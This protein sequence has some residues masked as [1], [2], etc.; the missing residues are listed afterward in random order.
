MKKVK[1]SSDITGGRRNSSEWKAERKF[2]TPKNMEV[3]DLDGVLHYKDDTG[4]LFNKEIYDQAFMP[5]WK[6]AKGAKS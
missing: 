4:K 6:T 5:K 2:I 1:V 3:V